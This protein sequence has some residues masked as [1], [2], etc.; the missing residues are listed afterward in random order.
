MGGLRQ[1][2]VR[3]SAAGI[4]I[5]RPLYS[6]RR[7]FQPA[8]AGP[9]KRPR[10]VPVE[11]LSNQGPIQLQG[12]DPGGRRIH[13]SFSPP[14]VAARLAAH[15][16]CGF[17]ANCHRKDNLALCRQ[18]LAP[19]ADLLPHPPDCPDWFQTTPA[20]GLLDTVKAERRCPQCGIGTM[21]RV[22]T[23]PAY[24]WPAIPPPDSS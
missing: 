10:L 17:L 11:R 24:R 20:E 23:L 8:P 5:S 2:S 14:R 16:L 21:I 22:Q 1:A 7:H 18:L 13:S 19:L 9:G 15:S 12:D 3:R 4:G 6:S